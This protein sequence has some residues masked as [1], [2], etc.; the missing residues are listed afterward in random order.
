[1]RYTQILPSSS[2]NAM[3]RFWHHRDWMAVNP[4]IAKKQTNTMRGEVMKDRRVQ[5]DVGKNKHPLQ[6]INV[7]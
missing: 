3:H 4:F 7:D 6:T 5:R 2:I 1:M